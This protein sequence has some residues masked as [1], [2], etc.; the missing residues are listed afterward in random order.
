M[1]N[2]SRIVAYPITW[3]QFLW[4]IY[5]VHKK[6]KFMW[7]T[8]NSLQEVKENS[9]QEIFIIPRQ[10]CCMCKN[11]FLRCEACTEAEGQHFK[12]LLWPKV[13]HTVGGIRTT[14]SASAALLCGKLV[15]T[16]YEAWTHDKLETLYYDFKR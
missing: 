3:L 15:V 14:Q 9:R 1:R 5:G 16:L 7:I 13:S 12:N 8:V 11:I 6:I 10:L 2:K 4:L